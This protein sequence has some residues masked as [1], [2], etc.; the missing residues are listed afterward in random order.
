MVSLLQIRD[1]IA[2]YGQ[3]DLDLLSQRLHAPKS[4]IQAMLDK[5]VAMNK[6]EKVDITA[7][8]TGTSCKGC[9]ESSNCSH[10]LYK[11]KSPPLYE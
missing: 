2:L 8:L 10:P 4:L 1:F 7:C 11:I 5:L 3:A 6:I 9:P